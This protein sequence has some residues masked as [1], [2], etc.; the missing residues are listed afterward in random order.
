M[1]DVPEV[2]ANVPFPPPL[3]LTG[4]LANNW[5]KFKRV[6]TQY[7]IASKLNKQDK[8]QRTAT[9]LTCLGSEGLEI[10]D[11]FHFVDEAQR[12]DIDQV[13]E[14]LEEF[15]IGST[16]EIYERYVFNKREQAP[17]ESFDTYLAALRT[18]S[19]TCNFG[20]LQESLIRDRIVVGLRDNSVR[21]RLLQESKLTLKGTIDICK[22]SET[23]HRQLKAMNSDDVSYMKNVK[24]TDTAGQAAAGYQKKKRYN[25]KT[26]KECTFCG[27]KHPRKKELCPA[28]GKICSKCQLR[29][30]FAVKCLTKEGHKKD[31]Q[32][33]KKRLHIIEDY[34]EDEDLEESDY[35]M[36]VDTLEET[37]FPNRI[38]AKMK[39]NGIVQKFQL[40]CGA[41]VNVIPVPE[42]IKLFDDKELRNLEES[43]TSLVM[44]DKSKVI[45]V[46]KKIQTVINPVNNRSYQIE[47]QIVKHGC[48]SV[49][50]ARAIQML[51]LIS[52]NTENISAVEKDLTSED[53]LKKYQSIFQ[54]EGTLPEELKLTVDKEVTPVQLPP[55]K[56][57]V[58]LREKYKE[59]LERLQKL[60]IIEPITKPTE[61]ISATVLIVKNGKIRLCIDPKPLNK[62]LKRS[63]YPLGTIDDILSD[64]AN[65][66]IFTVADVKNGFWHVCLDEE[67]SEKTTFSTPWGKFKWKR[68][69]FGISPAPE[70]FQRQLNDALIGLNGVHTVA[71]DILIFGSGK[72][73]EEA[74]RD[75]DVKFEQFLKRCQEKGIKLNKEK[76]KLKQSEVTYVGHVISASGLKADPQK[77]EAVA[78]MPAPTDKQGVR[79]L[80]GTMNYLQKFTP[81][82]AQ[83]TGPIRELMKDN[84]EFQWDETVHGKCF[85]EIR[86]MM[87]QIFC[88]E[89][90]CCDTV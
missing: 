84:V 40:D 69:P 34:S 27:T 33:S 7:E 56:P 32:T 80:L 55:R 24:K 50:G 60:E 13:M 46:G 37:E 88:P 89:D 42:Y 23:T 48:R 39:I 74:I 45:P 81:H 19:K 17:E 52:L 28:Y 66:R 70:E 11:S 63:H 18:M 20:D 58:A 78:Q 6:W 2:L 36:S 22:S 41:T 15:C 38:F 31:S 4:N 21:K 29:N 51:N 53:L 79:R 86:N 82:L 75:H 47:F 83:V 76:L 25:F 85:Q 43:K 14:K 44:Y 30:H 5:K 87:S 54:G 64:L 26:Q 35:M 73:D 77:I 61:W 62:A 90:R 59:E 65:A 71:D 3:E 49:L 9:L 12:S 68:M 57:P 72:T 16:N 10:V 8:A 67:S 1:P